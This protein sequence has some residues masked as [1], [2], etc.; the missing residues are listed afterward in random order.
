LLFVLCAGI[1][2]LVPAALWAQDT[3]APESCP[4]GAVGD[5]PDSLRMLQDETD[6]TTFYRH[7]SS[8][9]GAGE[10]AFFLYIG[11]KACDVWLRIR[12]QFP[13]S[14]PSGT[15]RIRIKADDKS[16]EF[17]ARRLTQSEDPNA[18]GYWYDELV[19]PDHLLMLF[20]VAASSHATVRLETASGAEEHVVSEREKQALTIVLGAYHSLGGK[21]SYAPICGDCAAATAARGYA[22]PLPQAREQRA[23]RR[24]VARLGAGA[25]PPAVVSQPSPGW[26]RT[27]Q[28]PRDPNVQDIP[29]AESSEIVYSCR[30]A[31]I[32]GG[33]LVKYPG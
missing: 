18:R 26:P 33:G 29:R 15:L 14:K 12:I 16:Y 31:S 20:K 24:H 10:E 19:E 30:L 21:L 32:R 8:P 11:K 4:R 13:G 5:I 3:K 22:A 28:N 7:Q 2:T 17:P 27:R 25:P 23:P 1:A 6:G 9:P